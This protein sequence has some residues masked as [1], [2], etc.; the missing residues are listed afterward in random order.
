MGS[1]SVE[2]K[3]SA[4]RELKRLDRAVIRRLVELVESLAAEPRPAGCKKLAG[5]EH[6]YRVRSGDY[7]VV[8]NV[9]DRKLVV[10][11]IR[12]GHRSKIYNEI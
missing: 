9:Q 11:V 1:Y 7:R 5:T 2:W 6:T 10:E 12:V 3:N 4:V 8:Y